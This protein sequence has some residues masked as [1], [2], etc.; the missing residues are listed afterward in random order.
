MFATYAG[1]AGS[2]ER[3]LAGLGNDFN[4]AS[5][6]LKPYACC[7][8]SH[9]SIDAMLDF[10]RER[11]LRPEDVDHIVVTAGETAINMLSVDP[12][13]TVFDAQFSLPYAISVAIHSRGV[14]LD[15][16]DP[17]RIGEP[18]IRATFDKI[19]MRLD[20]SIQLEDGPRLT[21][22]LTDGSAVELLAGNPT[23]ARGSA[24]RPLSREELVAKVRAVLGP[25]GNAVADDLIDAVDDLENAPDLTRLLH[26]LRAGN[27][28][29]S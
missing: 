15:Q 18:G 14:G 11:D 27:G 16:F 23:T 1:G 6:Y 29:P 26:A 10:I 5:A 4:V 28:E 2:A 9:S 13:E 20:T 8:G 22:Q 7:R 25:R 24:G 3:A 19:S 17:P 21:V 12:I